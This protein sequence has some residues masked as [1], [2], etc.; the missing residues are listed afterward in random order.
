VILFDDTGEILP[1]GRIVEPRRVPPRG[2]RGLEFAAARSS[3]SARL[4]VPAPR[5]R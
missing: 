2:Q 3:A 5:G 4:M 1:T